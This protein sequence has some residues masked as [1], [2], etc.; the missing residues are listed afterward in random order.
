MVQLSSSHS[1]NHLTIYSTQN[2]SINLWPNISAY[3]NQCLLLYL[4]E[5]VASDAAVDPVVDDL[6]G[7]LREP[8]LLLLLG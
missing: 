3:I 4:L 6:E 1:I 8:Q 7:L 2:K 5:L